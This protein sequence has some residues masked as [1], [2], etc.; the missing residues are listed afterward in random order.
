MINDLAIDDAL[1][2]KKVEDTTVLQVVVK[3]QAS[4]PQLV[5]D[6]VETPTT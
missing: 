3:G 4:N 6:S 5:V 1:I 2:W